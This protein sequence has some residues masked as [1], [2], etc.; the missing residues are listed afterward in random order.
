VT[1]LVISKST[2]NKRTENNPEEPSTLLISILP[3]NVLQLLKKMTTTSTIQDLQRFL[4]SC[5]RKFG[6]ILQANWLKFMEKVD[7]LLYMMYF[8]Q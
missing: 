1:A 4:L 8:I 2:E 7:V 5:F 6:Q 3:I